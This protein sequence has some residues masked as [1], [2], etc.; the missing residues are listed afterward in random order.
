M[1]RGRA[2]SDPVACDEGRRT[3]PEVG[4]DKGRRRR[5]TA[6]EANHLPERIRLVQLARQITGWRV[7][8]SAKPRTSWKAYFSR[9]ESGRRDSDSTRRLLSPDAGSLLP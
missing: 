8:L 5:L 7:A 9:C 3:V 4:R 6:S 2:Q 1:S